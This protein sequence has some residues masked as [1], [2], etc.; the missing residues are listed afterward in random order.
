MLDAGLRAVGQRVGKFTSPHLH[1]FEER[2]TV[3]DQQIS[4]AQVAEFVRQ[5][6]QFPATGAAFFDL[7]LALA[8]QSFAAAGVSWAVMEAGVGGLSDATQALG[9][10]RAVA[11]TNA[12][13]DHAAALGG[14]LTSIA[15]DKAGAALPEVPLLT[16]AQSHEALDVI[17]QVARERGAPLY[18]PASHPELFALPAPP[19][20]SGA[21]QARN[22]ALAL[23]TLRVL[24]F[25]AGLSAALQATHVGRLETFEVRGRRVVL[26]GAHNPHAAQAL[27]EAVGQVDTLLFGNFAR[28]DTA[29]TLA[30]LLA[31][32]G[33]MVF[34]AP[35]E[36]A[37][38]P[39]ALAALHG[40]QAISQPPAAL[41]HAVSLTPVGGTLLVTGS[42][43]LVGEVR[44]LLEV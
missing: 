33:R 38:D 9:N 22:A 43:Y 5:A 44:A 14:N 28:K 21:H 13:L 30:P 12:A 34:T 8:C 18:T 41:R 16:T 10:V 3:D 20:L 27:A 35:G 26:D 6:Q 7:S 39:Y 37:T 2:V 42:L 17:T 31:L 36:G 29:A 32:A 15:R 4:P 24:G 1:A 40:A 25:E 23:A 11:L 19:A